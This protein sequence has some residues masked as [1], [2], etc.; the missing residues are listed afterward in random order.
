ME[1]V[2]RGFWRSRACYRAAMLPALRT[3]LLCSC[4]VALACAARQAAPAPASIAAA[5]APVAE[6]SPLAD[7][8]AARQPAT[9]HE[10]KH[11]G[12]MA[13]CDLGHGDACLSLGMILKEPPHEEFGASTARFARACQ[14]GVA[15]GCLELGQA[16]AAG[17]GVPA[18]RAWGVS[19]MTQACDMGLPAACV[20]AG[21][22]LGDP[23]MVTGKKRLDLAEARCKQGDAEGCFKAGDLLL[24]DEMIPRDEKRAFSYFERACKA[25]HVGGCQGVALG[26]EHGIG[27]AADPKRALKIYRAQCDA[28]DLDSCGYLGSL[29]AEGRLVFFAPDQALAQWDDAC[30]RGS[31][32]CCMQAGQLLAHSQALPADPA[33][34]LVF[35][36]K[37][38]D[39]GEGPGCA[40]LGETHEYGPTAIDLAKAEAAYLKACQLR[41]FKAC[42]AA[43]TLQ[44]RRGA[45]K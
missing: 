4:S 29:A 37:A 33:R 16:I 34:S 13:L 27:V 30:T 10:A 23:D 7:E 11:A 24:R 9:D 12:I 32:S 39:L 28:G 17:R 20:L 22:N 21:M 45:L 44:A 6:P 1:I 31:G 42:E 36:Q 26:H 40:I 5:P 41:T 43:L 35:F 38:C 25:R 14:F 2:T 18:D 3:T 19:L 15:A 8:P